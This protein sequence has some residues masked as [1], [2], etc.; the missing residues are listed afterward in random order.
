MCIS[1]LILP[2]LIAAT[3]SKNCIHIDLNK[4]LTGSTFTYIICE[5]DNSPSVTVI[6]KLS[7]PLKSKING[8][9]YL[10]LI[11]ET[12]KD[13]IKDNSSYICAIFFDMDYCKRTSIH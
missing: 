8:K 13:F 7:V 5:S 6:V 2:Y 9:L 11:D 4:E 10:G 12:I 1:H 3:F